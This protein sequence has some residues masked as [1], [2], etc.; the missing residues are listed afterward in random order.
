[1]TKRSQVNVRSHTGEGVDPLRP[2]DTIL[3]PP[4]HRWLVFHIIHYP[5]ATLI[6][7]RTVMAFL[8]ATHFTE[9]IKV[10]QVRLSSR[11]T[12]YFFSTHIP[13]STAFPTY[14][15]TMYYYW[16]CVASA[17][18]QLIAFLTSVV[19][20]NGH[21]GAV[22]WQRSLE[23]ETTQSSPPSFN[24]FTYYHRPRQASPRWLGR[25][26]VTFKTSFL[27]LIRCLKLLEIKYVGL[28]S[29]DI[30][31]SGSGSHYH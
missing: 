24:S 29:K 27:N 4:L 31:K 20:Y 9:H 13:I 7:H 6:P 16:A 10:A 30:F 25:C 2:L 12:V 17:H 21:T 18:E 8:A 5:A 11:D 28:L 19:A 15:T 26:P 22:R 1:M 23:G 14:L 3:S